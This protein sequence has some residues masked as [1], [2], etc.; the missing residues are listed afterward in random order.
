MI[1][2]Y[3]DDQ[4][5][6]ELNELNQKVA[7]KWCINDHKLHKT[8]VFK[9]FVEAFG[10]MS[11]VAIY[12]EKQNHHPEWFNVYKTVRIDLTTH[13]AGGISSRDFELA[14]TIENLLK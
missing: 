13:E 5:N 14:L 4:I 6:R 1:E 11:K 2:K 9:N 3:S 7:E 10:F 12:A 8:F